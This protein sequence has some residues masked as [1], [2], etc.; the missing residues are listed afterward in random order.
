MLDINFK[1]IENAVNYATYFGIFVWNLELIGILPLG[2]SSM[3]SSSSPKF[4]VK[5]RRPMQTKSTSQVITSSLPPEA[6]SILSN[7]QCYNC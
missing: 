4:C 3:P 2:S 1:I 7:E 6:A 5:G